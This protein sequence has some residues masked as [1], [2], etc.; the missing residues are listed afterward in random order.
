[1]K[2]KH[3]HYGL[4]AL[5]ATLPHN[6]NIAA[7]AAELDL[8]VSDGW[9]Q[10][11]PAGHFSAVDG[12]PVDVPSKQWFIDAD[13]TQA[14]LAATPHQL[15]DL[16]IDYEHQTLNSP[17]NGQPNPAAG[18]FS[19]NEIDWREGQGLFIKPR[20]S[21]KALAYLHA[22]E[23]RYLSCV[24]GYDKATGHPTFLHSAALTNRPALDG[25]T[26]L[27]ELAATLLPQSLP[28]TKQ[29][30]P[31]MDE[32]LKQLL[33][34]LGVEVADGATI[35]PE[36][37]TTALTALTALTTKAEQ[38]EQA[39]AALAAE[40]E[41][42][43]GKTMAVDLTQYVPK[44]AYD[45]TVKQL[46]ALSAQSQTDQVTA[47]V[48]K[49]FAANKL[50]GAQKDYYLQLGKQHGM[51]VLTAQ[52]DLLQPIAAL[53]AQ[54]SQSL[55]PAAPTDTGL[56]TLTAEDK[57]AADLLGISYDDFAKTKGEK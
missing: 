53:S 38:T 18:Y 23:Y 24:F 3:T 42:G 17:K 47:A 34:P 11:L 19:V 28:P 16:V 54:Q 20:W 2:T 30:T 9:V 21:D 25:M 36:Q 55:P 13:V 52:L 56:A 27:A 45:E 43:I 6:S 46:A 1:M 31:V 10:L 5:S 22:K 14:M 35:T 44:A 57:I 51:A 41:K 32:W 48:D 12:R 15:G 49:A 4:A 50:T 40:T 39:I 33:A 7:L 26:P 29:E 37:R 8:N